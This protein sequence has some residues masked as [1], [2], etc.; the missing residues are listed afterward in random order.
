MSQHEDHLAYIKYLDRAEPKL[1]D[2][3][4]SFWKSRA[5]TLPK[6]G[7]DAVG[8][9]GIVS[10]SLRNRIRQDVVDLIG[11]VLSPA[12]DDA[13]ATGGGESP[14]GFALGRELLL[15]DAWFQEQV[16]AF[17]S[18]AAEFSLTFGKDADSPTLRILYGL[19]ERDALAVCRFQ[20]KLVNKGFWLDGAEKYAAR[21]RHE[22][23]ENVAGYEVG[24]A[25]QA[26]EREAAEREAAE[27]AE[28]ERL[29]GL[30]PTPLQPI[31]KTWINDPTS[32]VCMTCFLMNG[33]V[34]EMH[35]LFSAGVYENPMHSK[36]RC[37]VFYG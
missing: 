36:C 8:K 13:Y 5:H 6:D 14:I 31:Y 29:S 35:E 16:R 23:G 24:A 32:N 37:H 4:V 19:T 21:K 26:G 3:F 34:V 18:V 1:R 22:R 9:S 15:G 30:S 11:N 7:L 25:H 28:T 27:R 12:W 10:V 2:D 17:S 20:S 33:E